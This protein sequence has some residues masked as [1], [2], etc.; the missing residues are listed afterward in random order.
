VV[1]IA[2]KYKAF[3]IWTDRYLPNG[4][5]DNLQLTTEQFKKLGDLISKEKENRLSSLFSKTEIASNR[6]LQFLFCGGQPY[7]CSAG[8]TLLAILSNGD[9]LSCRRLPIRI[10]NLQT[11]NLIDLYEKS[12]ILNDIRN[13]DIIDKKCTDCYYKRSCNGGLKCLT[14]IATSDYHRKDINCW[15]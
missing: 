12:D 10:G 15:I 11:D 6:A 2:R 1:K 13:K 7:N 9:L 14:Y 4:K 3:K 5:T 8:D